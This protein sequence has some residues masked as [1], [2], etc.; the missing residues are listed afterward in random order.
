MA[1]PC[2]ICVHDSRPA[3]EQAILSGKPRA[4]IARNFGFTYRSGKTG[5]EVPDGNVVKKH[6]E[7]CM[8]KAYQTAMAEREN[9]SGVAMA[10][11]LEVLEQKVDLVIERAEKGEP[12]M[13]GDEPLLDDDGRQVMRFDNRLLLAAVREARGNVELMAKLAGAIPENK[14]EEVE[15]IRRRLESPEARKLLAALD[16]LDAQADADV[17]RS[18][19]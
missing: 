2:R 12:V 3:I 7:R 6:I 8:P 16:A 17:A 19:D 5:E 1:H 15:A 18:G 13:V 4:S 10:T 11:R 9:R 14:A